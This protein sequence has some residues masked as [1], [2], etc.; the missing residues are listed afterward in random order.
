MKRL[1]GVLRRLPSLFE[2]GAFDAACHEICRVVPIDQLGIARVADDGSHL[3]LYLGWTSA[4]VGVPAIEWAQRIDVSRERLQLSYPR[5][6]H[7][8]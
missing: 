1:Q 8:I 5:G 2:R 3:R 7:R 4:H 6:A